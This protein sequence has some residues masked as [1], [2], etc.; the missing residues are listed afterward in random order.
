[1]QIFSA[2]VCNMSQEGR[3]KRDSVFL[4]E[5]AQKPPLKYTPP[6]IQTDF[7]LSRQSYRTSRWGKCQSSITQKNVF[8]NIE[9]D[10]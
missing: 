10:V 9:A 5:K 2:H 7:N 1:M 3:Q 6:P 4:F 8:F